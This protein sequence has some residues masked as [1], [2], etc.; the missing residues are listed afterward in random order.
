MLTVL[1][2]E[3][4]IFSCGKNDNPTNPTYINTEIWNFIYNNDTNLKQ[5]NIF[6]RKTD[7]SVV[8]AG[9]WKFWFDTSKVICPFFDAS[10]LFLNDS[11]IRFFGNGNAFCAKFLEIQQ[12]NSTFNLVVD[13]IFNNGFGSG[14]W[15]ITFT[16][17]FWPSSDSG[18]Y[19]ASR[20]NGSGIFP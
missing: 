18:I 7:S 14:K 1:T 5:F 3:T 20:T 10:V 13:G 4:I 11:I 9:T 12:Q 16:N 19:S 2:V 6:K 8:I 15:Q 17:P